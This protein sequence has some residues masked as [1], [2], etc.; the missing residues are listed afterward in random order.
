M[1]RRSVK[2]LLAVVAIISFAL[3]IYLP[4]LM[5]SET[6]DCSDIFYAEQSPVLQQDNFKQRSRQICGNQRAILYSGVSKTPL[7][8]AEKKPNFS[9]AATQVAQVD[10]FALAQWNSTSYLQL[11]FASQQHLQQWQQL[12]EVL[13]RMAKQYGQPIYV[14]SGSDYQEKN[15]IQLSNGV[16]APQGFYKVVYMPDLGWSGGY[17]LSNTAGQPQLRYMSICAIE[18]QMKMQ[19]FPSLALEQKRE[20]YRWP[21]RIEEIQI[22]HLDYAYWDA[23]SQCDVEK[24]LKNQQ[25]KTNFTWMD[26]LVAQLWELSHQALLA[27]VAWLKAHNF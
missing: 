22:E 17:Y 24:M 6:Q 21:R 18:Q 3:V 2:I 12:D 15:L 27:V 23:D 8:W 7:W 11:P 10:G 1:K 25:E 5:P 13:G 14:V 26:T 20:V 4:Q 16:W 19:L 9:Q